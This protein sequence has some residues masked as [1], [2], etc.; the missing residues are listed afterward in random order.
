MNVGEIFFRIHIEIWVSVLTLIISSIA[1]A[2]IKSTSKKVKKVYSDMGHSKGGTLSLLH[3]RLYQGYNY[4][5]RIGAITSDDLENMDY[6][7]KEYRSLGGNGTC[8]VLHDKVSDLI[9]VSPSEF[10]LRKEYKKGTVLH[11]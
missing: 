11:V 3:D 10:E 9:I 1:M 7:Y 4:Y 2:I 8:K 6:M 5:L